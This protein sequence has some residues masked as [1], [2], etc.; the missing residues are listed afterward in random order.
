MERSELH[1]EKP[2]DA[3]EVVRIA[4]QHLVAERQCWAEP[5]K[6]PNGMTTPRLCCSPSIF[7]ARSTVSLMKAIILGTRQRDMVMFRQ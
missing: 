3:L 2:G 5:S 1:N 4:G 6:S 7:P